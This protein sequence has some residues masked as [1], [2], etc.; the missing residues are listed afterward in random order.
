MALSLDALVRSL[1]LSSSG[2]EALGK[3]ALAAW[4]AHPDVVL[5]VEPQCLR[6]GDMIVKTTENA[7]EFRWLL[8]A[9]Q[10]GLRTLALGPHTRSE[11]LL[12]LGRELALLEPTA[13]AAAHFQEWLW[14]FGGE[15]L[16][17][18]AADPDAWLVDEAFED[19][20]TRRKALAVTRVGAANAVAAEL[21][22]VA[23]EGG[24]GEGA[25]SS[26]FLEN[27][28]S[29]L[30]NGVLTVSPAGFDKL[31]S[32][33]NDR[34]FWV[35]SELELILAYPE[36]E[37]CF[38]PV[39]TAHRVV[40]SLAPDG[41]M[42]LLGLL[43]SLL[44]RGTTYGR[45]VANA[46]GSDPLSLEVLRPIQLTPKTVEVLKILFAETP[47]PVSGLLVSLALKQGNADEVLGEPL[48]NMIINLGLNSVARHLQYDAL[49][50]EA[51]IFLAK[52][53]TALRSSDRLAQ[54]LEKVPVSTAILIVK[55][56]P[57]AMLSASS[58]VVV[59]LM[60]RAGPEDL[61]GLVRGLSRG[62]KA[63]ARV[64]G[65]AMMSSGAE[66]WTTAAINEACPAVVRSGFGAQFL[67]PLA[68]NRKLPVWARLAVLKGL[69]EDPDLLAQAVEFKVSEMLEPPEV[70]AFLTAARKR[71][72]GGR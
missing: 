60:K 47:T 34:V 37:A 71:L 48:G 27:L 32:Q 35:D 58:H 12:R 39:Q 4:Q 14:A 67:L 17:L 41:G 13:E 68:E 22:A 19:L 7:D 20:K 45:E 10:A 18:H 1:R 9:H 43:A 72:G 70:R 3:K 25:G 24:S 62:D 57:P 54:L 69:E 55:N 8:F 65:Q 2:A 29:A 52:V 36:L 21:G 56:V 5:K 16:D 51:G 49:P 30:E 53:V 40:D 42:L 64:L 6:V 44:R 38:P 50:P 66:G 23:G 15:G 61:L 59:A 26:V 28:L 31:T 63:G 33:A 11:D 46:I